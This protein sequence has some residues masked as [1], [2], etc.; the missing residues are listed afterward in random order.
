LKLQAAP[1]QDDALAVELTA[2]K[3]LAGR[4]HSRQELRRKLKSR[5]FD[6]D[7]V[8]SVLDGLEQRGLLS[9]ERF[10]EGYVDQ[11]SRKGYG[12]L[13]IQAELAERG[14]AREIAATWIDEGPYD[15]NQIMTEAAE[16]KFGG[17]SAGDMRA[18]AKRGRFLQQR[19]FPISLV[20]RYLDLVREF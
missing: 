14:I 15:W 1:E 17:S 8:E 11:R 13:R 12:P 18:L 16:R 19:G 4:E 6:R 10:V 9:D 3:L 5:H 20:R 2:V 7:R